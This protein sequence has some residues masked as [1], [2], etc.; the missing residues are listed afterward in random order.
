MEILPIFVNL[1]FPLGLL[2]IGFIFGQIF[3]RRHFRS[4]EKRETEY[5]DIVIFADKNIP[6]DKSCVDQPFVSGFVVL[7]TDYLKSFLATIRKIFG[8]RIMSFE[9]LVK[10]SK[11][12]AILRLKQ[13]A[14]EQGA[15]AVYN[16]RIET[17]SV[18][19][20][21]NKAIVSV[22][23]FAYGTAIK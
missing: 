4:I 17:S 3:E 5:E 14:R 7:S 9:T 18:S 19:K 21:S 22:E 20:G 13:A 12:E 2:F 1:L 23:T 11:R 8:G 6:V 16:V 15:T 10:R